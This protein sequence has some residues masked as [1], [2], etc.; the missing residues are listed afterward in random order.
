MENIEFDYDKIQKGYYREVIRANN[1]RSR[2]HIEKFIAA[3]NTSKEMISG[4]LDIGCGPGVF[5]E[6]F[7][8]NIPR[9]GFDIAEKQLEAGREAVPGA[10]FI[11]QK[12][13]LREFAMDVSHIYSIELI[14]HISEAEFRELM[15]VI[16]EIIT[17]RQEK[18]K[19]TSVIITTPNYSSLWPLIEIFVDFVTKM[20]YRAQHINKYTPLKLH[21]A[22]NEA[23]HKN[24]LNSVKLDVTTFMGFGW[25]SRYL[26]IFDWIL[27]S[28]FQR[29]HLL[30]AKIDA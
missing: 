17:L 1:A 19:K 13:T 7:D 3:K 9:I 20:D 6:Y 18:N 2:W 21:N 16:S 11:S 29:G 14:E 8:G 12:D 26:R 28:M 24:G 27:I 5:L 25:I 23:L 4:V 22:I 30:C 10:K 15:D